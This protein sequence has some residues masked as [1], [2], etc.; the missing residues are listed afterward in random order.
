ML[1][2]QDVLRPNVININGRRYR[3][4]PIKTSQNF[5]RNSASDNSLAAYVE[6]GIVYSLLFFVIFILF[7]AR[8]IQQY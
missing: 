6:E 3:Q 5:D 2:V 4:L 8:L 7:S 1:S